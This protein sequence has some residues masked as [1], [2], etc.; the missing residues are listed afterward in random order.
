MS[1]STTVQEAPELITPPALLP[2]FPLNFTLSVE[3]SLW[4]GTVFFILFFVFC[5]LPQHLLWYLAH[6]RRSRQLCD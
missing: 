1:D 5:F 6:S 3:R 2:Y 4:A